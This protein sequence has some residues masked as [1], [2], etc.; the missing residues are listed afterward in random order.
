VVAILAQGLVECGIFDDRCCL[1]SCKDKK[2]RLV[3]DYRLCEDA[4]AAAQLGSWKSPH[5]CHCCC[6]ATH[7]GSCGPLQLQ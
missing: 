4:G 5:L 3:L 1:D 2:Q 7:Q 6:P